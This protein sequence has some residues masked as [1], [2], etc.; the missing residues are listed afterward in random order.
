MSQGVHGD[1]FT[2]TGT[3]IRVR[4][5]YLS[6]SSACLTRGKNVIVINLRIMDIITIAGTTH[7][8]PLPDIVYSLPFRPVR[9]TDLSGTDVIGRSFPPLAVNVSDR[10]TSTITSVQISAVAVAVHSSKRLLSVKIVL[11]HV[12]TLKSSSFLTE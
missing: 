3:A 1:C 6:S 7:P 5:M 4:E 11:F 12:L 8:D 2:G 9:R 10:G